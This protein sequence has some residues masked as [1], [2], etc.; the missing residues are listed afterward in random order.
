MSKTPRKIQ[1]TTQ[2]LRQMQLIQLEI[3]IEFDKI[4]KQ[5]RIAYSLDG[6]TLLGAIRHKGFIPWDDDIDV[7]M[8]RSEYERFFQACDN[9]L[10][11]SR[12]FLQDDK[13]DPHYRLGYSRL[14]RKGTVYQRAGHEHMKYKRGVFIDIF[15]L[16]NVPDTAAFRA[17]HQ[18]TCYCLRKMLWAESG[19]VLHPSMLKR[20]WFKLLSKIPRDFIFQLLDKISRLMNKKDKELVRHMT[21]PYPKR[22]KYGIKRRY[23]EELTEVTFEGCT[24]LGSSHYGEYLTDLYGSDYMELPPSEKRQPRIHLSHFTPVTPELEHDQMTEV[25]TS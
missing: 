18:F 5:N 19:K 13:T 2:Q 22:C 25:F 15:V 14:L 11:Q 10:D 17:I 24:F 16:D 7:I 8:L 1:L 4:C 21:Y 12:F 20:K 6:G 23:F 3:L 9:E